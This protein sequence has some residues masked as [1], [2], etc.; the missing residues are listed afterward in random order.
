M[1]TFSERKLN[2]VRITQIELTF[3]FLANK[4]CFLLLRSNDGFTCI[5]SKL[6][7]AIHKHKIDW[8]RIRTHFSFA[9]YLLFDRQMGSHESVRA[10]EKELQFQLSVSAIEWLFSS[11][12][13]EKRI[14]LFSDWTFG[15]YLK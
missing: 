9:R 15:C 5:L 6:T 3:S 1:S 8:F 14:R 10:K 13:C 12:L 11:F 4:S 2:I 7:G